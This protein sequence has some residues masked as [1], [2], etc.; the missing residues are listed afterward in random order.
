MK[1][2]EIKSRYKAYLQFR[3]KNDLYRELLA[4]GLNDKKIVIHQGRSHINFS[5]NDYLGLRQHSKLKQRA[6]KWCQMFGTGAGASRLVTGNFDAYKDLEKKLAEWKGF[7]SALIMNSGYQCN[8][9]ILP[10]LFDKKTLCADALVFSDKLIHASMYAGCQAANV[11]QIRFR[12]NDMSHLEE[13]LEKYSSSPQ[14]KFILTESIFSMDGDIPPLSDL[15]RL[16]DHYGAFLIIDEAHACGVLGQ[17]GKGIA[18]KADLVI[19]TFGKAMGGFGA[20]VACAEDIKK[21]LINSCDGL[22][23]STGLP[24][25]VLGAIDAA[26]DIVP[27]MDDERQYLKTLSNHFRT[28]LDQIGFD[29]GLSNTQIVS[30]MFKSPQAALNISQNLQ[31][32]GIWAQA[33]RP[34]T[35]PSSRV[36]FAIS[37][38]HTHD[39]FEHYFKMP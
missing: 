28:Q 37:T 11:K 23:Y 26:L 30:I 10:A 33:I 4:T 20:Y 27:K 29:Y 8:S 34:P 35:V 24:P 1:T 38:V 6:I 36:R 12:H 15:Y 7:E 14:P 5:S 18:D 9:T 19:G 39:D 3:R 17:N 2:A 21:Y 22:I 32:V 13:L 31:D 16:R 25:A